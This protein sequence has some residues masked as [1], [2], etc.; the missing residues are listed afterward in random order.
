MMKERLQYA[1]YRAG[2]TALA[3]LP[4]SVLYVLSSGLRWMFE[5]VLRYRREVIR[6]NLE[7]VF[8]EMNAVERR[9]IEHD[10]YCQL[11]DNFVETAKLLHI[12]DKEVNRRISVH[13]TEMVEALAREGHPIIVY[14]GHYGNWEWVPASVRTLAVPE[15]K[16]QVYKPLRD[17]A[18]DRLMLRVRSRFGTVSIEQERVFRT[19][20]GMARDGKQPLCGFIADQRSNSRVAHH[21][22]VFLGQPTHFNPGGEQIGDRINAAYV[23]LDVEKPRRGHYRFTFKRIVPPADS[24][25]TD[26]PYTREYLRMLEATIRRRPGLW[27]WSHR[28]WKWEWEEQAAAD[29]KNKNIEQPDK[30]E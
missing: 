26:S 24:A 16:S 10:F 20:V 22:T 18:F 12:S 30:Q 21:K 13:G 5:R 28:R 6:T 3:L 9:A 11:A 8:P 1:L 19:L 23:Y 4:L 7:R 25:G 29:S 14:L 27:L 2:F 17:K 15:F